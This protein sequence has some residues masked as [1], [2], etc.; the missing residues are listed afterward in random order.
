MKSA[1][2]RKQTGGAGGG[3]GDAHGNPTKWRGAAG[4]GVFTLCAILRE[5]APA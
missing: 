4:R 3:G 2:N 5:E 1:V